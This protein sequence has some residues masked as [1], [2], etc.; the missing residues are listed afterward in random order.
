ML[1]LEFCAG[2]GQLKLALINDLELVQWTWA[3]YIVPLRVGAKL[4]DGATFV[5]GRLAAGA[6][7]IG[8]RGFLVARCCLD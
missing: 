1:A 8:G 7:T 3:R 6:T 5:L 4:G 2:A